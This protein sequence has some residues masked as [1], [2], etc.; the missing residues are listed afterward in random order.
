MQGAPVEPLQ[1]PLKEAEIFRDC[2]KKVLSIELGHRLN[3]SN[4][5]N[6][7]NILN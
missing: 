7:P 2:G 4:I 6:I 5:P 3:I 1:E